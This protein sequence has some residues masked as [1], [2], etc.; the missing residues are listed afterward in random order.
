MIYREVRSTEIACSLQSGSRPGA[1]LCAERAI[2]I[3]FFDLLQHK[4]LEWLAAAKLT[5][6]TEL[7]TLGHLHK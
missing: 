4:H 7:P 3:S 5:D 2:S 6:G 1:L